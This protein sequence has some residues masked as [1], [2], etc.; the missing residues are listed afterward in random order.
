MNPLHPKSETRHPNSA[1]ALVAALIVLAGAHLG[2]ARHPD[3]VPVFHCTFGE[4]W[5]VNYDGWPDRW[6]RKS[7]PDYPHYVNIAIQDDDTAVGKKCLKIDLDG[8]AADVASPPIRVIS[9]FSY[10]F[11]AQIKNDN[12]KN[13]TVVLTLDF[14]DS[15]GRVLQSTKTDAIATTSGWQSIHLDPVEPRDPAIDHAVIGLQVARGAKGDLQGHVSLADLWLER[16]PRIDV[17]TN[18]PCNVYSDREGVVV[19]CTLSGIRER[20]P[21]IDFQLLDGSNHELHREHFRLD[22]RLI[23]SKSGRRDG[24]AKGGEEPDGYEGTIK[25]QP[26]IPDYG[27]YRVVVRMKSSESADGKTAS[28]NELASRTIDLVVVPPLEMPQEGEFGWTIPNRDQPLSYQELSRLLPQV[29]INWAK[30][31]IWFDQPICQLVC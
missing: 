21:E 10:V 9:R 24:V 17:S 12:L 19:E 13:S 8:A 1:P 11:E 20:E 25:W 2:E 5:D 3:A 23:V 18:N 29:G 27:C 15:S 14:C 26:K 16:L 6:D 7:G 28:Q 4:E 31:P 22:G 30:V